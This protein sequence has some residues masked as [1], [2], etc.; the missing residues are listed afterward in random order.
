[1]IFGNDL[2]KLCFEKAGWCKIATGEDVTYL[3]KPL[4]PLA[5]D[6]EP[7]WIIK[8]IEHPNLLG[9]DGLKYTTIRYSAPGVKWSEKENLEYKYFSV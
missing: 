8:K 1:M 9:K 3:G 7:A 5:Y 4:K 2:E 6:D